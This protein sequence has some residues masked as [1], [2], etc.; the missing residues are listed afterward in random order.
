[1]KNYNLSQ[2]LDAAKC[3]AKE[4]DANEKMEKSLREKEAELQKIPEEEI[5]FISDDSLREVI[6]EL[7]HCTC[8]LY[9]AIV[10]KYNSL[11]YQVIES[12]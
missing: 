5:E 8:Q 7:T 4:P 2:I 11:G 1:M 10:S 3:F 12:N 6:N 9:I